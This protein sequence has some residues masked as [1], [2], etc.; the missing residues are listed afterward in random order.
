MRE[1]NAGEE[2]GEVEQDAPSG[3]D[4]GGPGEVLLVLEV[5]ES[6]D[7]RLGEHGVLGEGEMTVNAAK[8]AS[9]RAEQ[10]PQRVQEIKE[11]C[12]H[13]CPTLNLSFSDLRTSPTPK[14]VIGSPSAN[15]GT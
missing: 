15:A 5:A 3:A 13:C 14:F 10:A 12:T 4:P 7:M 8:K 2:N 11:K 9:V 6:V 1:R